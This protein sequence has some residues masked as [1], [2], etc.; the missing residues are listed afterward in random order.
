MT[1]KFSIIIALLLLCHLF[2]EVVYG[3]TAKEAYLALKY[4]EAKTETGI[5]YR[6]YS[7]AVGD[8]WF[9]VKM[10]LESKKAGDGSQ[11]KKSIETAMGYYKNAATIWGFQFSPESNELIEGFKRKGF[12][13]ALGGEGRQIK[14]LYPKARTVEGYENKGVYDVQAIVRIFWKDASAE[15]KKISFS[16]QE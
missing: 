7:T 13:M 4:L 11:V 15:L 2:V 14:A 5:S 16:F 8:A 3:Q 6:D 1:K 10:F 12:I 9:K